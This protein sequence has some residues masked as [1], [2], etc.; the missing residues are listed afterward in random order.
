MKARCFRFLLGVVFV[1]GTCLAE[2]LADKG[3]S[4]IT[5]REWITENPPCGRDLA[6]RVYVLE[7]W[8]TWCPAC[9]ESIPHLIAL[10]NKYREGGLEF[11]ALSQDKSVEKVRQF[12][13]DKRINYCVAIDNGTADWFGVKGYPT[14]VVVN[15]LGKVVWQGYP[16]NCEFEKAVAKAIEA[17]PA[18]LLS[19]VDLGPFS[20]LSSSLFGGSRFAA[21][22]R[23]IESWASRKKECE[24]SAF[25][26]Q[27]V[28][29]IDRKIS[30]QT[31]E[32]DRLKVSD[33]V[34]AYD[35]YADIVSRYGDIEAV[36]RARVAYLELKRSKGLK[37]RVLATAG[38]ARVRVIK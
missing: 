1:C 25:A 11:I 22:Y 12:V 4:A 5:I 14:V 3:A 33:P 38:T 16:W 19:G 27:L 17:A 20:H 31:S 10:N 8:A 29:T 34:K 35:I 15:H 2:N 26:K 24:K 18:P 9:V 13:R 6:G 7:F 21:A 23:E 28:E 32:A 36:K 30:E 37:K